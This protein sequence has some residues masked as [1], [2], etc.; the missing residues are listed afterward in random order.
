MSKASSPSG[1]IAI[2]A[3]SVT[4]K[5]PG[6]LMGAS[7]CQAFAH[8]KIPPNARCEKIFRKESYDHDPDLRGGGELRVG[9]FSNPGRGRREAR[10][11]KR[12]KNGFPKNKLNKGLVLLKLTLINLSLYLRG[13]LTHLNPPTLAMPMVMTTVFWDTTGNLLVLVYW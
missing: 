2:S 8:Q 12:K 1:V 10:K 11:I 6:V 5:L 4:C 3:Q 7:F 9:I 13:G